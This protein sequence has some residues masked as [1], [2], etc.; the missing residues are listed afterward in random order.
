MKTAERHQALRD[1]LTAAA[2]RAI[3]SHGLAS[4]KARDLAHEA[5]CALGAIYTVFPDLDALVIAVNSRTL[6]AISATIHAAL[7]AEGT[8]P[9]LDPTQQLAVLSVAYLDYAACNRHRWSALFAHS[10]PAGQTVP[11]AYLER[12]VKLFHEV[13]TPL[14]LLCP[15]LKGDELSLLARSLFS[16]VHGIVLL[17]LDKKI[18]PIP[19]SVLRDQV[20]LLAEAL[21]RGLTSHGDG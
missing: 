1:T 3:S 20:R 14:S 16:A 15:N 5:G 9:P 8:A 10:L 17:G 6:D 4:L 18:T 19:A 7:H 21:A 12:Q 2:E 11:T 13:E